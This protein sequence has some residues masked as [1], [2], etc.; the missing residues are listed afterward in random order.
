MRA[1]LVDDR[2]LERDYRINGNRI[3]TLEFDE[4]NYSI[5][6]KENN[7]K[8][9]NDFEFIDYEEND[10]RYLLAYMFSPITGF[11]LGRAAIEYFI[12]MTGATIYARMQDGIVRNDGSH[13]TGNAFEFVVKMQAEGLIEKWIL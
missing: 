3:I 8:I 7:V 2:D 5:S 4:I 1:I 10:E 12:D 11:G 6:F 9:G 13:L